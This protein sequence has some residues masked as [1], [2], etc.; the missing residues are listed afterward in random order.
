LNILQTYF[1]INSVEDTFCITNCNVY[2]DL[3][4]S[5]LDSEKISSISEMQT[6]YETEKKVQEINLLNEQNKW[7]VLER[8][9]FI[10]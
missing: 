7:Q 4:D 9:I 10:V 1:L 3:K 2:S 8:N 6:K 5:L